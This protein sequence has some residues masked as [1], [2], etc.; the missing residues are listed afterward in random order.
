MAPE[1][2]TPSREN[3]VPATD[4]YALGTILYE[5]LTGRPPFCAE[6]PLN[7]LFQVQHQEPVSV[8][9][10]QPAVP[11]DLATI[12]MKCLEKEPIRR[13]TS[14]LALAE[15]LRRF[16][17]D[18]PI[19]ARP[20]SALYRFRK[21]TLRN[22]GLVAGIACTTAALLAGITVSSVLAVR[23]SNQRQLAE[24]NARSAEQGRQ[25]ALRQA[26][27]ARL[28]ATLMALGEH[29]LA[30]AAQH[31]EAAPEELR[32]WEWCHLHQR[33]LD[34]RPSMIHPLEKYGEIQAFFPTGERVVT[35]KR[36]RV[37]LLDARSGALVQDLPNGEYAETTRG[38]KLLVIYRPNAP[39]VLVDETETIRHTS[40]SLGGGLDRLAV[41]PDGARLLLSWD[42]WG[43][44]A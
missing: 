4:V 27:K 17:G 24:G 9:R 22:K 38:G 32:G 1:Q 20:P 13:Y 33:L 8:T 6:T 14:A 36:P 37:F 5:M 34:E 39:L 11:R 25:A 40:F 26:Y 29:N 19:T 43:K 2:A 16:Q 31:I 12:T 7:T 30:E 15:D 3:V 35:V 41:S 44:G 42:S 23:E 21:F 18:E 10:L 28:A